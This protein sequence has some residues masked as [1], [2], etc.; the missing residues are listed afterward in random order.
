MTKEILIRKATLI[1]EQA[2][3]VLANQLH[4][5]III[6]ENKFFEIF[7]SIIESEKQLL[8]VA[9]LNSQIIGYF[10]SYVHSAIYANGNVMYLDEIVVDIAYRGRKIGNLLMA[11]LEEQAYQHSCIL[12]SLATAGAIEF[13]SKLD[14]VVK[15]AIIKS[16][17]N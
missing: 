11:K 9:E 16:I 13:Y 5:R 6:N 4:E 12:I 7:K 8:F 1:D 10:S 15:Q 2:I 14:I 3:F 17:F